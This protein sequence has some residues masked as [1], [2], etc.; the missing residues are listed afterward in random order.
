MYNTTRGERRREKER[1]SSRRPLSDE[2]PGDFQQWGGVWTWY[3]ILW[4]YKASAD[5][6]LPPPLPPTFFLTG[7]VIRENRE[8]M[9][10]Q[11]NGGRGR[12]GLEEAIKRRP[13]SASPTTTTTSSSSSSSSDRAAVVAL[14][15]HGE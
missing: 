7:K 12:E 10:V 8:R 3:S 13:H 15:K 11:T 14:E 4:Q 9:W 5:A 2:G 1:Y 6:G